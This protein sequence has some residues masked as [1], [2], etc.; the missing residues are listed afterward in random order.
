[1][2]RQ[3]ITMFIGKLSRWLVP[4]AAVLVLA[5]FL[6]VTPP[7]LLGKADGI[8]YAV[9]H[10]IAARS[11]HIGDTA[12]PLCARCTG[13]FTAAAVGL[14][15]Q[16]I[17]ARKRTSMPP[18]KI[19][20]PLILFAFAWGLDGS[21]SYLYLIKQTY[22]GALAQIPNLYIPQNWL[23]LLTGSGMGLG[24][25]AALY[26]VFGQ[27]IWK[28][29][30]EEPA[31]GTWKRF[32]ILVGIML[33]IDAGI[34]TGWPVILYPIAFISV[35]G[36]LSL[37]VMVYSMIWVM[38]FRQDNAFTS[39]KSLWLPLTAGFTM[40]MIMIL[41]IDLFRLQLTGTWGGFP[42]G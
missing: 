39:L 9:C 16:A 5:G 28:D 27:T 4:I 23:R 17:V 1:M 3:N 19:G 8:G 40:A 11:F 32:G 31:L 35:L 26:P 29:G 7:G 22:P 6:F 33:L 34:L 37:L 13:T 36:T 2:Q 42:L 14:L 21:N 38:T 30:I 10:R 12:L 41:A 25:A 24:M 18:W 15:F 20:I